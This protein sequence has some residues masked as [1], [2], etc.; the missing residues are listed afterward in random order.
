MHI[1]KPAICVENSGF[2]VV[3][4]DDFVGFN[5]KQKASPENDPTERVIDGKQEKAVLDN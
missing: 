3:Q 4:E 5:T 1:Y 2:L